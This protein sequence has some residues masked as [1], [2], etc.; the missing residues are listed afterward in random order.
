MVIVETIQ[1]VSF[2]QGLTTMSSMWPWLFTPDPENQGFVFLLEVVSVLGLTVL[3]GT[4]Q[5]LSYL[6]ALQTD[7]QTDVQ[8]DGR[9]DAHASPAY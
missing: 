1:S 8:T 6:Q 9:T 4:V 2:L 7:P 5:S 3:A